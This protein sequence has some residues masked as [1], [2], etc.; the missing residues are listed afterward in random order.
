MA[1][2]Q[3]EFPHDEGALL[4]ESGGTMK[5]RK[6]YTTTKSR[7]W[8]TEEEH[9]RFLEALVKC[10]ALFACA[11]CVFH[12]APFEIVCR[13]FLTN[14]VGCLLQVRPRLEEDRILRW[15]KD[16]CAGADSCTAFADHLSDASL[17][18]R[19][20]VS[21]ALPSM[22]IR[23]HAQKYFLKVQKLGTGEHV[24]PPRPKRKSIHPYPT[25][26]YGE[27]LGMFVGGAA[28]RCPPRL[29][30]EVAV[31]VPNVSVLR[32]GKRQHADPDNPTGDE[33]HDELRSTSG[34]AAGCSAAE[35][36]ENTT[37]GGV[38]TQAATQPDPAA[39]RPAASLYDV[40]CAFG[41]SAPH[42]K[43]SSLTQRRRRH[44]GSDRTF[45]SFIHFLRE[46]ST[47]T[48]RRMQA[49]LK[50]SAPCGLSIG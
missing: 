29:S 38:G 37:D 14:P 22:Q 6:P 42:S 34:E 8:W 49:R 44:R 12:P 5:A 28:R 18:R 24:P 13:S 26:E 3:G 40:S 41:A 9:V 31:M 10:A 16:S 33:Y 48:R 21:G 20:T 7:E 50:G 39:V 30:V 23:S 2:T 19:L 17:G 32:A 35:A 47:R 43:A 46:S 25:K 27:Q 15:L 36:G 1:Q 4:D 45:A 11:A